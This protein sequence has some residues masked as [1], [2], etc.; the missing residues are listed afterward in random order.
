MLMYS[1]IEYDAPSFTLNLKFDDGTEKNQYLTIGSKVNI[2]YYKGYDTITKTGI[3]KGIGK[4][5]RIEEDYD[6][7]GK[8]QALRND[9]FGDIGPNYIYMTGIHSPHSNSLM[10]LD[11]HNAPRLA[12]P[13]QHPPKPRPANPIRSPYS[14]MKNKPPVDG[15][16]H[17]DEGKRPIPPYHAH[18][19]GECVYIH[20]HIKN[21][22][23]T[24]PSVLDIP[25]E[26]QFVV[27]CIDFSSEYGSDIDHIATT[28]IRDL[29]LLV[30]DEK[31]E[32]FNMYNSCLYINNDEEQYTEDSYTNF[33][34]IRNIVKDILDNPNKYNNEKEISSIIFL[35][36]TTIMGLVPNEP[37]P[38]DPDND[39]EDNNEPEIPKEPD[40]NDETTEDITNSDENKSSQEG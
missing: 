6:T 5:I 15:R 28:N 37:E 22:E 40:I 36:N 7:H 26:N 4:P 17:N 3:I 32:L 31:M 25:E 19:D 16:F 29:D 2:S 39:T 27:L 9:R 21:Y 23:M 24:E 10:H 20:D 18:I 30:A 8:V 13:P 34:T 12:N 33:D 1:T 11:P 35:F 38:E 14:D